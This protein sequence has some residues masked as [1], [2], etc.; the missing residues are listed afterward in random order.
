[1]RIVEVTKTFSRGGIDFQRGHKYV[2][3]EDAESQYRSTVG[4]C[5][6]LSYPI[7]MAYRPYQGQDLNNK[8]ILAFRTGGIG[9]LMFLN[10]VLRYIKK[11]YPTC[12]IKAASGCK[13]PLENLP[14]ISELYD[15][16]FDASLMESTR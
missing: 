10:P 8:S 7:E 5:M 2:L 15:M 1:M 11:R 13:Q 16:P 14:E 12:T 6:G 4:E 9:D 3:A